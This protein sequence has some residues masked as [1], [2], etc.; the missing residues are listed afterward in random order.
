LRSF[1]LPETPT[2]VPMKNDVT[3]IMDIVY[4]FF[5]FKDGKRISSK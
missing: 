1:Y 2:A 5:F 4:I 3:F